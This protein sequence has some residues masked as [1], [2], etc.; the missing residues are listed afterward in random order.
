M[1]ETALATRHQESA[2]AVAESRG[3]FVIES[4]KQAIEVAEYINKSQLV[5]DAYRCKPADIV[6]AMQYGMELGLSPLQALQSVAVINGKPS[7]YGD[8]VPAIVV[9]LPECEDIIEQEAQGEV[10]EQWV[11]M[12]TV[13]RRGK[14]PK[15]RSF[16]WLDAKRAG[17]ANKKGPWT[18][19]PKRML[20]MRARGFAIRDAFPDRMKGMI[21][22]EEAMD[23]TEPTATPSEPRRVGE[24]AT[25]DAQ[26]KTA[27]PSPQAS[28][29]STPAAPTEA[30]PV[31]P[32]PANTPPPATA[33]VAPA[34]R[35][36][37]PLTIVDTKML[38]NP[39]A[40]DDRKLYEIVTSRGVFYTFDELLYKSAASCEGTDTLFAIT[41]KKGKKN[42]QDVKV[43]LKLGLH[44]EEP[45]PAATVQ[46]ETP[47]QNDLEL[48]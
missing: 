29:H 41:W 14:E 15:T 33:S 16:S 26:H 38:A 27:S 48:S 23:Y 3:F 12:C 30:A 45:A 6:I 39:S 25:P 11:A 1:S 36:E 10:P 31:S 34:E 2:L 35:V 19:Y 22:A 8:A 7:I 32:S 5:P 24:G 21:L 13:K 9:G 42:G 47:A 20:L 37:R 46:P 17:L 18:D 44:E 4:F 28:Q 40:P 43:M